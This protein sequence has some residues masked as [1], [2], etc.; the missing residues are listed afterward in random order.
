MK[1]ENGSGSQ[2][3]RRPAEEMELDSVRAEINMDER[4][5]EE[6]ARRILREIPYMTLATANRK[7]IPWSNPVF[8]AYD[9]KH[10]F[11]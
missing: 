6:T 7:S 1:T 11:Y 8:C 2:K 10:N 4:T 9:R 3:R 5:E